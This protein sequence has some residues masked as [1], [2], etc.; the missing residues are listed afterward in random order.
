MTGRIRI[1]TRR[2]ALA[3]WQARH[4]SGLIEAAAP[5]GCYAIELVEITTGGDRF[6]AGPLPAGGGKG[7][8]THELEEALLGGAI[9]LAVHSLKDLP[10]GLAAG[11]CLAIPPPREDPRDALCT[12]GGRTLSQLR[13]GARLGTSSLRRTVQLRVLRPDLE[14]VPLRGN[15]PTRLS[16]LEDPELDGVVL[17]AAGL[18]RLGLANRISELF[19][20]HLLVPAVGQGILGLQHREGDARIAGALAPFGDPRSHACAQA[21]RGVLEALGVGCTVPM[22][23]HAWWEGESLRLEALVVDPESG[24][25]QRVMGADEPARASALGRRLGAEL[26]TGPLAHAL[27]QVSAQVSS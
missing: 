3:L 8:F 4:V 19:D 18:R 20:P 9:D 26:L 14:I 21:E 15:V 7:L 25:Q 12:E 5:K 16:R 2:S 1:G 22:G 6:P 17:A 13:R 11:T 24:A 27:A 10:A 23:A